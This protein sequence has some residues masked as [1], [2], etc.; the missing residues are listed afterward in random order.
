MNGS[1]NLR[2]RG[3]S[4]RT[5]VIKL[6]RKQFGGSPKLYLTTQRKGNVHFLQEKQTTLTTATEE[7]PGP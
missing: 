2:G 3:D 4:Q 6:D 5:T 7:T 1:L